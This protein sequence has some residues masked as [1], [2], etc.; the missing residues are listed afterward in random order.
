MSRDDSRS[1]QQVQKDSNAEDR[2]LERTLRQ[3]GRVSQSSRT[4]G[5][6]EARESYIEAL[7]LEAR[8]FPVSER[9]L[10]EFEQDTTAFIGGDEHVN[11]LIKS[12]RERVYKITKDDS[13]GCCAYYNLS[14]HEMTGDHFIARTNDDP[15]FYLERWNLLNQI[16]E[17]STRLEGFLEPE[18]PGW[19]PRICV[20]QPFLDEENPT[21]SEIN[22]SLLPYGFRHVSNGAYYSTEQN[23]LLTDAFPRNVRI[24]GHIPVPFDAIAQTPPDHIRDWLLNRTTKPLVI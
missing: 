13:F 23:I 16:N 7:A 14:D 4:L 10:K 9:L 18:R 17:Y 24:Q 6:K 5:W 1:S 3:L 22:E 11:L 20:S 19:A 21:V 8:H 15:W 12:D 2:Q